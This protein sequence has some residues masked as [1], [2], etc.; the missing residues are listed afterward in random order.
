MILEVER[1]TAPED[2]RKAAHLLDHS[3]NILRVRSP[4]TRGQ[5]WPG[6]QFTAAGGGGLQGRAGPPKPTFVGS[7]HSLPGLSSLQQGLQGEEAELEEGAPW[8]RR[9]LERERDG[10][11]PFPLIV[12]RWWCLLQS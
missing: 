7:S 3:L 4:Q 10:A 5:A 9:D 2:V 6:L 12:A 1:D 11:T 8:V